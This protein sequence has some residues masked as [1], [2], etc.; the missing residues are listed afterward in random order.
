MQSR[1]R[2]LNAKY[3]ADADTLLKKGDYSQASEK[4]WGAVA[5]MIK[6]VAAKEGVELGEHKALW[7]FVSELDRKHPDQDLWSLF[8][9]AR[10]LRMNFYEDEIPEERS[11]GIR[12][13][14][15]RIHQ[16]VEIAF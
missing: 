8:E 4:Y 15:T 13:S 6:L 12:R 16:T 14:I 11:E 7:V 3:I 9:K 10:L 5:Q 1:H 2:K